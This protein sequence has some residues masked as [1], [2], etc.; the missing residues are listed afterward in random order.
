MKVKGV[1]RAITNR[2]GEREERMPS[3]GRA[4]YK[5]LQFGVLI[6]IIRPVA[7]RCD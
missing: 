7:K 5:R 2:V 1:V 4:A 6:V 3:R